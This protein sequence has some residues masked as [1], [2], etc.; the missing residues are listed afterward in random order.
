MAGYM[1]IDFDFGVHRNHP[2]TGLFRQVNLL[3][4]LVEPFRLGIFLLADISYDT[5]AVLLSE[6]LIQH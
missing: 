3:H 6:E 4:V 2:I 1:I 5:T